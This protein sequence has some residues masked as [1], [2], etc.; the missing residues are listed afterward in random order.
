[1]K[2]SPSMLFSCSMRG[3]WLIL[4]VTFVGLGC[5][6]GTCVTDPDVDLHE[7]LSDSYEQCLTRVGNT[8]RPFPG[9]EPISQACYD[10]YG[11]YIIHHDDCIQFI[12]CV[13][14]TCPTPGAVPL[15]TVGCP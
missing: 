5:G 11:T 2:F 13:D 4:V 6:E 9:V 1:M 12:P 8:P 3:A 14:E 10:C 7:L 15:D